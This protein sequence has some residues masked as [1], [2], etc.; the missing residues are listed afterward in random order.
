MIDYSKEREAFNQPIHKFGQVGPLPLSPSPQIQHM[1]ANSYSQYMA[2]KTYLYN[3]ANMLNIYNSGQRIDTDG[4]KLYCGK[5]AKQIAD[6]AI[7]VFTPPPLV[8]RQVLGG[9][10]YM[11]DNVVERLWRD[12]KLLE[13]GGGTVCLWIRSFM[14]Q[15]EAHEKNMTKDLVRLPYKL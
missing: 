10:G 2:G 12:S 3:T 6:N 13:I 5:M 8:I 9:Y 7:Q 14:V 4:V 15:N 1:I 11:G